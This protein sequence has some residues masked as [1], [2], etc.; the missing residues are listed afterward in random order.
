MI[1]IL[2]GLGA[3][4]L[5][6]TANLASSRSSRMIGATSTVAWMMLV[7]LLVTTPLAAASGPVPEIT[8]R[9]AVWLGA[10]GMGSVIGLLLL[11][12][13]LRLGKIGVVLALASTEGAF[14]AVLSVIAGYS[15]NIATALVLGLIAIGIATVALAGGAAVQTEEEAAAVK[16]ARFN[17]EEKAALY[18]A[19]AAIAFGFSIYGTAQAGIS[20]PVFMAVLPARVAGVGFVFVPMLLARRLQFSWQAVPFIIV[21][22]LAEVFGNVSYVF[23]ARDSIAIAS[24]LASQFAAVA[25]IAA[26]FL[27]R[28]RLTVGQR[29]G[30][31][32]IAVGLAILTLVRG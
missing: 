18:G 9:L 5:W 25:A 1:A 26:F 10:S 23:G 15:L 30:F 2:G 27:F 14:A 3:A 24:V 8:P 32:A 6:A 11:Y 17:S 20:L 31:V 29:S 16:P 4:V 19:A 13:G 21:I 12:R 22:A 28:E 7:G